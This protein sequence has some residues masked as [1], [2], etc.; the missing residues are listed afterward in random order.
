M[1]IYQEPLRDRQW[2]ERNGGAAPPPRP[3][4]HQRPARRRAASSDSNRSSSSAGGSE[5][6]R[7]EDSERNAVR[8]VE[9]STDELYVGIGPEAGEGRHDARFGS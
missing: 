3:L 8:L 5:R 2:R 6:R 1:H 4:R 9:I 7:Q